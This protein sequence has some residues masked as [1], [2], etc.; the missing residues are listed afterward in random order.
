[1]VKGSG[2]D[3]AEGDPAERRKATVW[4]RRAAEVPDLECGEFLCQMKIDVSGSRNFPSPEMVRVRLAEGG[5]DTRD[6]RFT[7]NLECLDIEIGAEQPPADDDEVRI[8]DTGQRVD[9]VVVGDEASRG[10]RPAG[11]DHPLNV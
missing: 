10:L 2:Q 1:M 4:G 9:R 6:I 8:E 5:L 3:E 7:Q 11:R